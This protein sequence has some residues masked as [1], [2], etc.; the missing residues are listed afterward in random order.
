MRKLNNKKIRWIIRHKQ[1]GKTNKQLAISQKISVR[2]VKALYAEY[3]APGKIPTIH[4]P[5]RKKQGI[6][7]ETIDLIL[8]EH[9]IQPCNAL[10]LEKI[11]YSKYRLNLSHNTIHMVLKQSGLAKDG[12]KKQKQRKWVRYERKHSLSL[13]HTDWHESK[14]VPGKH[15]I[16]YL[17]DASRKMLSC[18]EFN[19]ANTENS[20]IGLQKA[21]LEAEPFGGINT[22][23]SDR[24]AQFY[25]NK[26]DENGEAKH[27]FQQYLVEQG[28]GYIASGVNHPQTNGKIEKWFDCYEK[29]R[30]RFN[31]LEEFVKWYN[32]VRVHMSLN[33][34][35]AET[36]SQAFIRKL[37]P[38]VWFKKWDKWFNW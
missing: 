21:Q 8:S 37:E 9:T 1:L 11:V 14:A 12:P 30:K 31:T 38:A 25:P 29:H 34:R 2:W 4:K 24:G 16:A 18:M 5:G 13:V 19:N 23:L 22:I 15:V 3:K 6:S 28:I 35:H 17:D 10:L 32:D 36:P 7:K 26:K 20:I 33:M 27:E